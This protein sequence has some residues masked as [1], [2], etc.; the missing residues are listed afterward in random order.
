MQVPAGK[1]TIEFRFE[2]KTYTIGNTVSLISSIILLLVIA[3]AIAYGFKKKQ[4]EEA[5]A[6]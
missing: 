6:A 1:H 3:G 4:R 2:P 5:I